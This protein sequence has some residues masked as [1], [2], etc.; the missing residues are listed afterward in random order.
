MLNAM[1][2]FAK[3]AAVAAILVGFAVS[4]NVAS[5]GAAPGVVAAKQSETIFVPKAIPGCWNDNGY[6]RVTSCDA[7]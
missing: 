6:N 7:G 1:K 3:R 5:A 4:G 2:S